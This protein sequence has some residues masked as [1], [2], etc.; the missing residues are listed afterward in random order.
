[1][2]VENLTVLETDRA[3]VKKDVRRVLEE[4]ICEEFES[5]LVIG[6]KDGRAMFRASAALN[7][8]EKLGMIEMAKLEWWES[9]E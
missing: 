1:M 6:I 4:A 3:R 7:I 9:W 8:L 2:S 5:V